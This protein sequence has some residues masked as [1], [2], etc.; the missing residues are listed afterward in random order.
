MTHFNPDSSSDTADGSRLVLEADEKEFAELHQLL[1][2]AAV[3]VRENF[4]AAVMQGLPEAAGEAQVA[5][6]LASERIPVREGFTEH[7]MANLPEALWSRRRRMPWMVTAAAA[8]VALGLAAGWLLGA[9]EDAFLL[10]SPIA[11]VA[12]LLTVALAAGGGFLSASWGGL[13]TTAGEAFQGS[14]RALAMVVAMLAGLGGGLFALLRRRRA[15]RATISSR[16]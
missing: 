12:E 9:S 11:A 8:M 4:A 7:V 1:T 13:Q 14:P 10:T 3:S 5:G 2:S 6:L 16:H 15:A